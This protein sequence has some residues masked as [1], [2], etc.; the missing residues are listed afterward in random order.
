MKSWVD[1][2]D[3][4]ADVYRKISKFNLEGIA[5]FIRE[6]SVMYRRKYYSDEAWAKFMAQSAP[7]ECERRALAWFDL[8]LEVGAS[9]DENPAGEKAQS[10][11]ER[12]RALTQQSINGDLGLR[13][14]ALKGWVDHQNW[15]AALQQEMELFHFKKI[16]AF[17]GKAN[18][19]YGTK[20]FSEDALRKRIE[21]ASAPGR[22]ES[23]V[24]WNALHEDVRAA[25]G[26]DPASEKAQVLAR[27]SMELVEESTGGDPKIKL[28]SINAWQ[29]RKNWPA[30]QQG[31]AA[32]LET[33]A[34]FM[35]EPLTGR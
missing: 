4:P 14:G 8:Y 33:T 10:L 5:R 9:L 30:W 31:Y 32:N 26:E 11:A 6:A 35:A 23:A 22:A 1:R 13:A 15:P 3:W 25:L 21:L 20:Y 16:E 29:D 17:I 19:A 28:G 12:W 34:E 2:E 18:A 7:G 27:R 24:A